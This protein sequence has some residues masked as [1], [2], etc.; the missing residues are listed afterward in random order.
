LVAIDY[1]F[2][3][4]EKRNLRSLANTMIGEGP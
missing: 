4:S 1:K 3:H 2:F